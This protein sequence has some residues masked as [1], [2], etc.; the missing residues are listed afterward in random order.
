MKRDGDEKAPLTSIDIASVLH[1]SVRGQNRDGPS[2]DNFQL[3][4]DTTQYSASKAQQQKQQEMTNAWNKCAADVFT[5]SFVSQNPQYSSQEEKQRVFKH[6]FRSH[7][8][9]L[10][11]EFARTFII[12][13]EELKERNKMLAAQQRRINVRDSWL[14]LHSIFSLIPMF[15]SV[16]TG[17]SRY[18]GTWIRIPLCVYSTNS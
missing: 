15:C 16:T 3:F 10:K 13:R 1:W 5:T 14:R 7:L 6:F 9:S 8:K 11:K 17:V 18:V 2:K 4:L 12:S